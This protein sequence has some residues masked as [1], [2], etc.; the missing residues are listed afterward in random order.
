MMS[1]KKPLVRL[2][3][4]RFLAGLVTGLFVV[5]GAL[6]AG[7]VFVGVYS[8]K[9]TANDM[10]NQRTVRAALGAV[11]S[12]NTGMHDAIRDNAF[13]DDAFIHTNG[14]DALDWTTLNWGVSTENSPLYNVTAVISPKN[15]EIMAAKDGVPFIA[16]WYFDSAFHSVID[17]ARA[18]QEGIVS[19]FMK[20][21]NG[22][23]LVGASQIR[24]ATASLA[25]D[26]PPHILVF[27]K[28]ISKELLANL[29]QNF[30]LPNLQLA[31]D[32]TGADSSI[33]LTA[34][35]NQILG[36]LTWST[37]K[38]GT[39]VY[40]TVKPLF[41]FAVGIL[42]LFLAGILIVGQ[43]VLRNLK[44][45]AQ[46]AQFRAT[47][48]P[49]TG[50]L[51]RSGLVEALGTEI[52]NTNP[53]AGGLF[54]YVLDLDR[55]KTVN[56]I[57][58]HTIGDELICSVASHLKHLTPRDALV[59]RLG[60]D[61][62]AVA[63]HQKEAEPILSKSILAVFE[64][65][66]QIQALT[67]EIG[68]SIGAA[69]TLQNDLDPLEFLR[70]ADVALHRSKESSR[71]RSVF[72][73]DDFDIERSQQVEFEEKLRHA[74]NTGELDVHFQ[75]LFHAQTREITGVEA[76]ARW[77]LPTGRIT[78]DVFIPL[79]ERAGLID[80]L[81][82]LV[83]SRA[84]DNA[85]LWPDL[86]VCVNVSPL[87][88][89]NP[90][91]AK[92]VKTMLLSKK[93]PPSH[94]ILEITEN[95]LISFPEQAK[96]SINALQAIG[97]KFALD[98][99]G[100]GY[101]SLGALKE[102]HFDRMKIDRSLVSALGETSDGADILNATVSLASA[103]NVPVTAEGIET[104]EQ[105]F[106]VTTSGCEVLQGF[107]LGKPMKADDIT[108]LLRGQSSRRVA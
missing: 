91:F 30:D 36:Y 31:E 89:R 27:S 47:H 28:E 56:D 46:R 6:L 84:L 60:G 88:L 65:P 51:N 105:A 86:E 48:D 59:A 90:T 76:L 78:P 42:G 57:W 94:L 25:T 108:L 10:D 32:P 54:L 81:G 77:T 35:D 45:S 103:L 21:K 19:E 50:L 34:G 7:L 95:V 80:A 9:L 100:C 104:E 87:Q 72:Y 44:V 96:R 68:V 26:A 8:M 85:I 101:A 75:P 63:V 79:A 24:P 16:D 12:L 39:Q 23:A 29:S 106:A 66:F 40:E 11:A 14:A 3:R 5:V 102:F 53:K 107:L 99:F 97:V 52:L 69:Q 1:K 15:E 55:F 67:V 93:F 43:Y 37:N 64:A 82:A 83:L 58:G 22:L 71:G 73:T 4:A 61:E 74:I 18:S 41:I 17:R 20:T 33:P 49:L 13:W 70:R 62:F 92:T 38:P 2:G 98:D